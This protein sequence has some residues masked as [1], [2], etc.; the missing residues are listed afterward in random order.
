MGFVVMGCKCLSQWNLEHFYFPQKHLFNSKPWVCVSSTWIS[1]AVIGGFLQ[2][3]VTFLFSYLLSAC[4]SFQ[5]LFLST[6]F[7]CFFFK[8]HLFDCAGGGHSCPMASVW[9]SDDICGSV[10]SPLSWVL[11]IN[12]RPSGP[13]ASAF[14]PWAVSSPHHSSL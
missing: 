3:S 10:F 9:R 12:L 13:A 7:Y 5:S 11:R 2:N 1:S 8:L 14:I 4:L 6:G